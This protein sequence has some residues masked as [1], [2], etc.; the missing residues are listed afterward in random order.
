M[1]IKSHILNINVVCPTLEKEEK[2]R[3]CQ[4][5]KN[6]SHHGMPLHAVPFTVIAVPVQGSTVLLFP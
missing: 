4:Q 2:Q 1:V 3:H 5:M 6:A